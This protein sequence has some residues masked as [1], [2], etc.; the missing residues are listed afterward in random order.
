MKSR[1][2]I[3]EEIKQQIFEAQA[4]LEQVGVFTGAKPNRS[5]RRSIEKQANKIKKC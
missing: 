3:A 1:Q 2:E 4:M 5:Q